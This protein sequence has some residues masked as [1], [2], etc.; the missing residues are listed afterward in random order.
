V[1]IAATIRQWI[2][3]RLDLSGLIHFTEKKV[4]PV[5]RHHF[6]Y[7]LGGV[8]L[9]LFM[10]Q[11]ITGILLLLY[12]RPSAENAYESVEFIMT[13]VHYGWL[14]RSI[15]S[16]GANLMIFFLCIHMF[17]AYFMK[18]YRKPREMTWISGGLLLLLALGFGFSGYLL[19][20][21]QKAY[22]ATSVGTSII[23]AVPFIGTT[24]MEIARGG[25][26]IGAV[27]LARFYGL[28]IWWMPIMLLGLIGAHMYLII[29]IGITAPPE[30]DE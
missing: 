11:I 3:E 15:H 25:T 16:W 22:W 28:H 9:F 29:R 30:R 17:S 27:T 7:G 5:H 10:I 8:T 21:N 24:L 20:W 18:A 1:K 26:E 4:V 19:P 6:W 14:I 12:Y 23:G 2:D 13:S